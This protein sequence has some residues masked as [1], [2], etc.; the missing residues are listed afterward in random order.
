MKRWLGL[1]GLTLALVFLS[2]WRTPSR[3]A[4]PT[5][6]QARLSR[7]P[8]VQYLGVASCTAG[9]CHNGPHG[10]P[11]SEY[12]TWVG[13]DPHADA[14]L[15]LLKP[16][17]QRMVQLLGGNKPAHDDA[18]CL[19]CH[20]HP[21]YEQ[22]THHSRFN[23]RDGV[24]CESC[25]GPGQHWQREHHVPKEWRPLSLNEKHHKG[26][27]NTKTLEGRVAVCLP[28]HVGTPG[29]EVAH[30]LIA[31]GHPRLAFE[32][33]AYHA[34]LPRHWDEQEDRKR[35]PALEA[36]AWHEGQKASAAAFLDLVESRAKGDARQPWPEFADLDCFACHHDLAAKSWRQQRAGAVGSPAL[37]SWYLSV[38]PDQAGPLADLH[39][40]IQRLSPLPTRVRDLVKT[41]KKHLVDARLPRLDPTAL[42]ERM[43]AF[44][45]QPGSWD[46]AVQQYQARLAHAQA[47]QHTTGQ[48]LE[49]RIGHDLRELAAR[50][51]F[52]PDFQS[53]KD[54]D[55]GRA[56]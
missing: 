9:G 49:K 51:R 46:E 24:G 25:H 12:A 19:N 55:P 14:Y 42:E 32:F 6:P 8:A 43:M 38:L 39:R 3:P 54:F 41:L 23:P 40:E 33:S 56:P 50:L 31:A 11:G 53:P 28:C 2:W 7:A 36:H 35:H 48:P 1:G 10:R 30:D 21:G 22:A 15:A 44:K 34:A 47:W 52:P 13:R 18:R 5:I 20:V 37:S 4:A 26:M 45:E 16:R 29:N 27:K 17:S